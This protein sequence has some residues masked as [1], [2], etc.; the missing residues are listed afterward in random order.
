[1]WAYGRQLLKVNLDSRLNNR[2]LWILRMF[3]SFFFPLS[4]H[5]ARVCLRVRDRLREGRKAFSAI[6][7]AH[8]SD[9]SGIIGYY[10]VL[11]YKGTTFVAR[12]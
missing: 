6:W 7:L 12:G 11:I 1:M 10:R 2:T 9:H 3:K 4:I 5:T 8:G